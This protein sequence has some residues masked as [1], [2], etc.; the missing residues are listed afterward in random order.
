MA[1]KKVVKNKVKRLTKVEYAK[2]LTHPKWQKKRL[3]VF[4]RDKWRCKKCRD[5]ETTLHVH[6]LKY[7]KRYPYNELMKNLTTLCG[8]CHKKKHNK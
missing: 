3:R 7:T 6:H 8:N 2:A 5:T 1:K 4:N